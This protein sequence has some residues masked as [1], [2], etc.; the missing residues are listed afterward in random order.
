[1]NTRAIRSTVLSAGFTALIA[2]GAY[3]AIPLGPVPIVLQNLFIML[4]GLMLGIPAALST[5]AV[6]LLLGAIGLPIFAGGTGGI[7]HFA[8]PTGGYLLAYLPA[9]FLISLISGRT[10]RSLIRD[11][12]ALLIGSATVYLIGIA[13][14]KMVSGMQWS[15][16]LTAGLLPFLPG[17]ILKIA[18]ALLLSKN[19]TPRIQQ[20]LENE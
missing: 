4:T 2:I 19:F 12:S 18:V 14:L 9:V 3:I 6:Y 10:K 17:D 20:F 5:V 1:M 16:A 15:A 11:L 7:G 13:W 8:G